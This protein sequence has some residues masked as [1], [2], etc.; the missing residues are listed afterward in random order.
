MIVNQGNLQ[1]LRRAFNAAFAEGY[2]QAP[3]DHERLITLAPSVT[4]ENEYGWLGQVDDLREWV[5]ERVLDDLTSHG[6]TIRNRKFERTIEVSMDAIDDDQHGVYAMR[7]RNLGDAAA[8]HPCQLV[9]DQLR[10]G[11]SRLCYDGQN[12]FDTDHPVRGRANGVS[13]MTPGSGNPPWI[14]CDLSRSLKPII[15]QRRRDYRL[16]RMDRVEDEHAF[17][18]EHLRYGVSARVNVGYGLWQLAWGSEGPLTAETYE[19]ARVGLQTMVGDAGAE[20]GVM[21][22]HLV[23][24]PALEY[25]A[26]QLLQ[27][28]RASNGATNV[29]RGT[30]ELIVSPWLKM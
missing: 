24:A 11:F 15:F 1:T 10:H 19:A 30:A 13:N 16:D 9:F 22:T 20:M 17:M 21:P 26:R 27:A 2:G 28:E 3:E 4:R 5:G 12:F 18:R 7:F 6:Y 8:R 23:V 14:L 25:E 29:W